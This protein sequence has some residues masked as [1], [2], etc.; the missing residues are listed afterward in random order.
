MSVYVFSRKSFPGPPSIKIAEI[1]RFFSLSVLSLGSLSLVKI[2]QLDKFTLP[3]IFSP[4]DRNLPPVSD[5]SLI[6]LFIV[7]YACVFLYEWL[8]TA[9]V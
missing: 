2:Y 9:C 6:I 3:V 8:C 4:V 1:I 7:I 5:L